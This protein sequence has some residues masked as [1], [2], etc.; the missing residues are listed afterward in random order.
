MRT[1]CLY[2]IAFFVSNAIISAQ[3]KKKE[4][5]RALHLNSE[6]NLYVCIHKVRR[7]LVGSIVSNCIQ[8]LY[9]SNFSSLSSFGYCKY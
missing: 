1:A 7:G 5:K 8:Q 2:V 4:D 9:Y 3:I 6:I